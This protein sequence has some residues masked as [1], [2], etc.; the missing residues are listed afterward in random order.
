[1]KRRAES[2]AEENGPLG[3]IDFILQMF[4]RKLKFEGE[5]TIKALQ[6]IPDALLVGAMPGDPAARCNVLYSEYDASGEAI[7][8][9]ILPPGSGPPTWPLDKGH[10]WLL[11][12]DMHN[13]ADSSGN[14]STVT[15]HDNVVDAAYYD[16]TQLTGRDVR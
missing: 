9:I 2:A 12:V 6:L 7:Y 11:Q 5:C 1:M 3:S 8:Q 14:T 4:K 10:Y 13:E 15:A 16:H